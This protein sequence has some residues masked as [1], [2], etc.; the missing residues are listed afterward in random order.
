MSVTLKIAVWPQEE[1]VLGDASCASA[2]FALNASLASKGAGMYSVVGCSSDPVVLGTSFRL[3]TAGAEPFQ[4]AEVIALT[5]EP[6]LQ[7]QP[8]ASAASD[9]SVDGLSIVVTLMV[10]GVFFAFVFGF[11][12]GKEFI[13]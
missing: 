6:P 8:P 4:W 2:S 12:S 3:A 9:T 11:K 7:P 13:K 10:L 5:V 1:F